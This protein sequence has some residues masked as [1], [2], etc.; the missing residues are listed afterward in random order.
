MSPLVDYWLKANLFLL[1]F[2][3]CY[4]LLLRRHTFLA[5]NRLYLMGS[6]VLALV[7]PLIHIPGLAF[8][9]PWESNMPEYTAVSVDAITVVGTV[10]E[11][12]VPLLPDWPMLGV[13]VFALVAAGLLIRT[14]WRTYALLRL[15]RQW[16]AQAYS[17][18]TLVLPD[19]AQTPTF[20]FFRYLVL[21]PD[22][23][24][25]EAIRQHELVHIRQKHSLDVLLLEILQALCWPNP[26]LFGYHHAIRQVH[27]YLADR[28]VTDQTPAHRDAYARFLV[29]YTFHL[30]SDSLAH[31]F[32]PDRPDSPTLKQRIQMLYQQHT[33]RRALWKYALVLPLATALLAMTN[34][35]ETPVVDSNVGIAIETPREVFNASTDRQ[36]LV[37]VTGVVRDQ[38][39]K[40]LPGANVVVRNGYR[41]TTTD[42]EGMFSIDVPGGTV[43]VASFVGFEPQ[44]MVVPGK[45]GDVVLAYSLK[46]L[47]KDGTSMPI[48][49]VPESMTKPAP[50]GS[51]EVFTVAERNPEFPGGETKMYG[52]I[53]RE[54]RYPVR[55]MRANIEGKVLLNFLVNTDG[56]I[57]QIKI[58]KGI[59][60]GCDDE[61]IRVVEKMPRW[62]PGMQSGQPVAVLCSLQVDFKLGNRVGL[63]QPPSSETRVGYSPMDSTSKTSPP[64]TG[65]TRGS[66]IKVRGKSTLGLNGDPLFF[67]NGEEI[68][69]EQ[70]EALEPNMIQS[71]NVLKDASATSIYGEK[72]RNGVIQITT[73][74]GSEPLKKKDR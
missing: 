60:F 15:I 9:W 34:E 25:A 51:N 31:S 24:Q 48:A 72:G 68:A 29:N 1:L 14:G 21:N 61:A 50:A 59:Q 55:A 16:P 39:R 53:A 35:P 8:P 36:I 65:S 32:G 52:F 2:Y 43:L 66:S 44:S 64:T 41:G 22:D 26:A 23:A 13:W 42:A 4:A 17:D 49:S 7:L 12:E 46:P 18:H 38:S 73:K 70:M 45:G 74:K 71:I 30:P 67:L 28:D 3:G 6:L 69:K 11:T 37:R 40:P 20:S 19:N 57:S 54:L 62:I 58:I 33:R 10:T 56:S 47:S 5:L 63:Y 27:E